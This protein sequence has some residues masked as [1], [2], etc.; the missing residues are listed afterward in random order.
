M[1]FDFWAHLQR[2]LFT[3]NVQNVK[4]QLALRYKPVNEDPAGAI[5]G[6]EGVR[7]YMS[8][9]AHD[10]DVNLSVFLDRLRSLFV[11]SANPPVKE[12]TEENLPDGE[13]STSSPDLHAVMTLLDAE[14][15]AARD[16]T[17]LRSANSPV[18]AAQARSSFAYSDAELHD[19]S[20]SEPESTPSEPMQEL[21]GGGGC[22]HFAT[23][24]HLRGKAESTSAKSSN[25]HPVEQRQP[26]WDSGARDH[27]HPH[28]FPV[29]P[30]TQSHNVIAHAP[31]GG[32]VSVI[33]VTGRASKHKTNPKPR[34]PFLSFIFHSC[35]HFV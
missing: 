3:R 28:P 33:S 10:Y 30:K 23:I 29:L 11:P 34:V 26:S 27:G 31:S 12:L 5:L 1:D 8:L 14:E 22:R 32:G 7:R 35:K 2:R 6:E 17:L 24:P 9:P 16:S 20:I 13:G 21:F 4:R 18:A 25:H 19:S 15:A